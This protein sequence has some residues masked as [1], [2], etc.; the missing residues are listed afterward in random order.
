[1]ANISISNLQP[2]GLYLLTDSKSLID[3]MKDLLENELKM[4]FGGKKPKSKKSSNSS[5]CYCPPPSA[6]GG[7]GQ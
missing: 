5:G 6:G 7:V 1:M 3:S 2:V 4:T